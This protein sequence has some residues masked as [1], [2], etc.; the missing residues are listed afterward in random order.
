M[1]TRSFILLA[2]ATLWYATGAMAQ[3]HNKNKPVTIETA[4]WLLGTWAQKTSKGTVYETWT[5]GNAHTLYGKS[6]MLKGKDTMVFETITL[7]QQA[8]DLFYI[9]TVS[10]QNGGQAVPFKSGMVTA[11]AMEFH[12]PAHDF[13]Q[14]ISY[15]KTGEN[16]LVATISG[17][18]GG[19][20]KSREFIM[21]RQP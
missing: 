14:K 6:Y 18:Q 13:P 4:A 7:E 19:K 9:P 5:R 21:T 2:G 11:T 16:A 12:N 20:V 10:N 15:R 17:K 8:G 3:Q 1:F